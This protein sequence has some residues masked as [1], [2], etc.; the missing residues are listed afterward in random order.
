MQ[1]HRA[2][3]CADEVLQTDS[4][5]SSQRLRDLVAFL[6][7]A[8]WLVAVAPTDEA[9]EPRGSA[10]LPGPSVAVHGRSTRLEDLL[11]AGRF[12]LAICSGW[13]AAERSIPLVRKISPTT[14][15]LVDSLDLHFVGDARRIFLGSRGG[16]PGLLTTDYAA[17]AVGEL[18]AYAAADAVLAAS[19]RQ[20]SL[21][22][23]LVG[24]SGLAYTVPRGEVGRVSP[25]PFAERR[26]IVF[27]GNVQHPP[28]ADALE[29]LCGEILPRVNPSLL[30]QHQVFIVGSGGHEALPAYVRELPHVRIVGVVPSI[31][32]YLERSRISVLPL[33]YPAEAGVLIQ[34]LLAGTPT[35]STRTGI[36]DLD[37][38]HGQQAMVADDP[39]TFARSV[40]QLLEDER[41]W[42]RIARL[43]RKCITTTHGREAAR[44][45]FL[46]AVELVL[47]KPPKRTMRSEMRGEARWE[48][49]PGV[50]VVGDGG[51]P[52]APSAGEGDTV[53]RH[54]LGALQHPGNQ[55]IS[56][57]YVEFRK[58]LA[59][60]RT[61]HPLADA[62]GYTP[63]VTLDI[64]PRIL[65]ALDRHGMDLKAC[66]EGKVI[67]DLG[68][69]DGDLSF[70]L[71]M[72][73]PRRVLAIDKSDFN[74]NGLQGF[75]TLQA[76]LKSRVELLEADAHTLDFAAL[77][78]FD[79]VF[80]FGFLYHSPHPMW[81]LENL[82]RSTRTLLL[83]TKVFDDDRAYAYFYDVA[84]C[85]NDETNWWCFTPKAL[86]LMLKR[87]GFTTLFLE[88]LDKVVGASDPVAMDRDGR[89]FVGASHPGT[90]GDA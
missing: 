33:R 76:A 49:S 66:V 8:G 12:T 22:N 46:E 78:R 77:G 63:W 79:V 61:R 28:Y 90:P 37:L 70:F 60:T 53:I 41:L 57:A 36:A 84:E 51:S 80:C 83:T 73:N 65:S 52:G 64:V 27:I 68:C 48:R 42:R 7:G 85:N 19:S 59:E 87:A 30:A 75:R 88:R 23:D 6:Q 56:A 32:P 43:G 74:Y 20:A 69:G 71:E 35:V 24:D 13:T 4:D 86:T 45:A 18:N 47:R 44:T 21:I 72:F 10:A 39:E 38:R 62:H 2:L 5:R 55:E 25:I 40:E 16:E 31:G 15:I 58:L 3:I 17:Q 29:Y 11:A 14:R 26:G 81:I 9:R 1:A 67:L 82:G 54:S 50:R 34:A 89:V